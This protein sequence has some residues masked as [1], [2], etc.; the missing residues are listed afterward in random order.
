[1]EMG[2]SMNPRKENDWNS[3]DKSSFDYEN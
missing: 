3:N 2:S 1:M